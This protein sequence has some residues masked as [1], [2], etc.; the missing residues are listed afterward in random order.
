MCGILTMV[1]NR[2][3]KSLFIRSLDLL[4]HRGPDNTG[5]LFFNDIGIGHTR[6]SILDLSSK[7]KQPMCDEKKRVF[8]TYNG[9]IYNFRALRSTLIKKGYRFTSDTD[10]EVLT[11]GYF[12]WGILGLVKRIEGMFAFCLYDKRNRKLYAVRDR[13]GMKPLYYR[14]AEKD[15]IISSEIKSILNLG[16]TAELDDLHMYTSLF[17]LR[18]RIGYK[19]P[20][21]D[22]NE[23]LPGYILEY[24][25][26][27]KKIVAISK[28]FD[29]L[30]LI[31]KKTYVRNKDLSLKDKAFELK[32]L[33]EKSVEKHLINDVRTGILY[34]GGLDSSI[35]A[36][37]AG[38]MGSDLYLF[39]S[40]A[41]NFRESTKHA[42]SLADKYNYKLVL[43]KQAKDY[44]SYLP[45]H[46][47]HFESVCSRSD[48]AYSFL[49]KEAAKMGV[50]V[51][52]S[53]DAADEV[54]GGY[55]IYQMINNFSNKKK[56]RDPS[57]ETLLMSGHS[58]FDRMRMPLDFMF[59]GGTRRDRWQK[60]LDSYQFV[61]RRNEKTCLAYM[62]E[63]LTGNLVTKFLH[64]GDRAGM[65]HSVEVRVPFLHRPIVG[66]AVNLP[67][68]YKIRKDE[69][70][71]KGK[72]ILRKVAAMLGIPNNIINR[73]K[74]GMVTSF[75]ADLHWLLPFF[76]QSVLREYWNLDDIV[77]HKYLNSNAF[78]LWTFLNYEILIR[79]FMKN[80]SPYEISKQIRKCLN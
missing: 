54:F 31:K 36:A 80:E 13:V 41:D 32:S 70:A 59:F 28:Y 75:E 69:N 37:L 73:K 40:E 77:F 29:P 11:R 61:K 74:I 67:F 34:S 52:L 47:Y 23:L 55:D 10:T 56:D 71:W 5:S 50:K 22:I 20:F 72:Y 43:C 25:E 78:Y 7:G 46:I 51:L 66:F 2:I 45:H 60:C 17:Y 33:L 62:L 64:R 4:K 30:K 57:L 79:I 19:T 26:K 8:V 42:R 21:K 65:M 6:L 9:E 44:L 27:N 68:N 24:D 63:N 58:D 18:N 39:H 16:N 1:S 53:G 14:L 49:C 76:K 12:E 48:I 3:S 38:E 35:I 15:I